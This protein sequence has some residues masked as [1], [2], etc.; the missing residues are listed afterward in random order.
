MD[1]N[2]SSTLGKAA[3]NSPAAAS[4]DQRFSI[5]RKDGQFASRSVINLWGIGAF[6]ALGVS[7]LISAFLIWLLLQAAWRMFGL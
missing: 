1:L 3:R 2:S 7:A 5:R 4:A 6:C